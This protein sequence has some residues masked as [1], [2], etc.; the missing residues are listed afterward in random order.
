MHLTHEHA[1]DGRV[2][3]DPM[4]S[5]YALIA[6][7]AVCLVPAVHAKIFTHQ[8][9]TVADVMGM[10]GKFKATPSDDTMA[11]IAKNYAGM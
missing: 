6:A 5:R 11:F 3:K 9:G 2:S 7:L 10:H 8:W 4:A 1:K